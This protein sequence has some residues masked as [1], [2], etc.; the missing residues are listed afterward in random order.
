MGSLYLYQ[1]GVIICLLP[2]CVMFHVV[3]RTFH[4]VKRISHGVKRTLHAVKYKLVRLWGNF[5]LPIVIQLLI[6]SYFLR[7]VL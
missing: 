6:L 5:T 2:F 4:A 3:Q 1:L 7:W